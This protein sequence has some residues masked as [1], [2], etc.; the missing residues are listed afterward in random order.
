M[1]SMNSLEGRRAV[2]TGGGRGIGAAVARTLA[3]AGATVLLSARSAP[4]LQDVVEE[5]RTE[6][7]KA[8]AFGC[9]VADPEQ[10]AALFD[11]ARQ[12]MGGVDILVNNAGIAL[13]APLA[14]TSLDDWD[15]VFAVNVRGVYLCTQACLPGMIAQRWGRVIN[16]ASVAGKMG[17]TYI[18]CYAASK[19]AVVGFT[20]A[21]AIEAAKS[22][23][24]VNAVCPGY[25]ATAMTQATVGN[26]VAKT[27]RPADQAQAVLEGMSPQGRLF[28]AEEVAFQ[29]RWLC[30]DLAGGVN[31]Q[32]I[33][34]DGGAFQA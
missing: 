21:V 26:I 24:T 6:G 14:K 13:A 27:G 9:D 3:K 17:S 32:S 33:V 29:V 2:V 20:R 1:S 8:L 19:H 23:V 16:V 30:D 12:Q 18:S 22:G 11:H 28:S 31:G 10:V 5:L 7:G 15:R 34:L 4:Q 25:V